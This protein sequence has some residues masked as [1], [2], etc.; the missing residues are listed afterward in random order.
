[1]REHLNKGQKIHD[2]IT[3]LLEKENRT[4]E[5]NQEIDKKIKELE[6][7]QADYQREKALHEQRM[8][9]GMPDEKETPETKEIDH[10]KEFAKAVR[11]GFKATMSEGVPGDGGYTV[12]QD[13]QTKINEYKRAELSLLQYVDVQTTSYESGSRVFQKRAEI[14]GFTEVGEGAKITEGQLP[15]F[16]KMDYKVKK[17]GGYY[18]ATMELVNDSDANIVDV[19]SQWIAR[20]SVATGNRVVTN[21][22]KSFTTK[23]IDAT[24]PIDSIKTILNVDLGQAYKPTSI[25]I[26]NDSGLDLLDHLKDNDGKYL[27]QA[28]PVDPMQKILTAGSTRIPLVVV[29]NQILANDTTKIPFFIGDVFEGVKH[30]NRQVLQMKASDTASIGVLNAFE[31]D[32]YIIRATERHDTK[33]FDTQAV[34]FGKLDTATAVASAKA[35]AK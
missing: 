32:L 22:L 27:L 4:Q 7:V 3:K 13:I 1:M 8:F 9:A 2:E 35:R 26:T 21:A 6:E 24:N 30:F 31:E 25:I 33:V 23:E 12:P 16:E 14:K 5:D 34:F 15:K 10:T 29:P 17:Y 20:Q 19:L 28:S 11:T 18:P